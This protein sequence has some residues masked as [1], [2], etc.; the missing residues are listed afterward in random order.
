MEGGKSMLSLF[1]ENQHQFTGFEHTRIIDL[2][3]LLAL[4]S[5]VMWII[6]M[7]LIA[8]RHIAI[9][10]FRRMQHTQPHESLMSETTGSDDER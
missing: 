4:I 9:L 8:V 5:I 6:V 2:L 7:L 10:W 1:V 3:T